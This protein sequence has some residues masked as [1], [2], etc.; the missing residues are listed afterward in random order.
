MLE[1]IRYGARMLVKHPGFTLVAI[2]SLSIG[3][4][5]TT[6]VFGLLNAMLLRPLPVRDAATLVSVNKPTSDGNV[7]IHTISHP[8]YVDYRAGTT[9][10]FSDVIAWTEVPASVELSGQVE[11]AYGMLVS[12]NYFSTL[13]PRVTLG[14]LILPDEDRVPGESP[15]V[16]LSYA[17]WQGRFAS[18]STIVGK[19]V[20]LNGHPFTVVGVTSPGFTSTYGAFAPAF[21]SPL[22]MQE[23]LVARPGILNHRGY[24]NL[25][26]TARLKPGVTREQA[27][28]ALNLVDAQVEAASPQ[29][30]GTS[31]RPNLGVQL[32]PVGAYPGSMLV[33]VLGIAALLMGIVGSVLLIACANVAGMLLA[34]ASVRRREMAVRLAVGAG[35]RRLIRQLLT[36]STLLFV[37]AATLGVLLTF[38]LTRLIATIPVPVAIPFAL[39]V[40]IDWRVLF[41]TLLL[42]LG[43]GIVFG[44]APALEASRTDLQSVLK[45]AVTVGFKRSRL[46]Q[47]FVVGQISLSLILLVG[48]G[49]ATRALSYGQTVYPGTNPETVMTATLN[50]EPL[51]YSVPRARVFYQQLIENLDAL[52]A[53]EATS[54]VRG[55][56][57]GMGYGRSGM[58]IE[59]AVELGSVEIESNTVGP[60]YFETVGMRVVN[61]REFTAAD[62]DGA[63][64]VVVVNSAMVR[65]FWPNAS[66]LGKRLRFDERGWAEVVGVVEDGRFRLAGQSALPMVY[67]PFAQ[68]AS[69][70]VGMTMVMRYRGDRD[71]VLADLRRAVKELDARL[72]LQY[73]MTLQA[74]V[75]AVTLPWKIAG[76]IAQGFGLLG[77]ALAAL[78]IYG[79][80]AYTVSQ[81]TRE[82]GVR[83]ALGAA[84]ADIRKLVVGQGLRLAAVGV[85]IGLLLSFGVTRA[86]AAMLFGVSASDPLTYVVTAV[87]LAA[88]AMAASY[89]PARNATRTDP[90][91][92]LRQD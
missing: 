11:Q 19:M 64:E 71:A 23:Q 21:Y 90:L 36:E 60:R 77:L 53:I 89:F 83:V 1:D 75:E 13:A 22:A 55:L 35:R 25:K 56:P 8:D 85:A 82:I 91:V 87:V 33:A 48:A 15:V 12:G 50:P 2:L 39:D 6:T 30:G 84:P 81:R 45:D 34:R 47:A 58:T 80:V 44:L 65:Q 20:T 27:H 66:P 10:V 16:V 69:E 68:S 4:G 26:I 49:L 79:L 51:G 29:I 42:A 28:A 37:V 78:G 72:P 63:P 32:A 31:L 62:R 18:D 88:V 9:N 3:I 14:R 67:R 17:F 40:Q 57:I 5:A 54:M 73:P 52:P 74:A 46:R 61:G 86:L 7:Q 59:D 43:T 70:N 76:S 92:A 38:W 24:S 41:F